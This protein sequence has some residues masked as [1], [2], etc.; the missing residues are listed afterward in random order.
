MHDHELKK[1][2]EESY[3]VRPGQ[4]ERAWKALQMRLVAPPRRRWDGFSIP[5][6]SGAI[7]TIAILA[8]LAVFGSLLIPL[9]S[10]VP[11]FV[12]ADSRAPGI[13]AT[14]FYSKTARAQ[15][16]WLNGMEPASDRLTYLDPTSAIPA[17]KSAEAIGDPN[18]L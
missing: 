7:V 2:L 16:V 4:E 13:Y 6:W 11:R 3:P 17:S 18:S 15:V 12:S 1:L 9:K 10:Y 14:A 8:V 5:A